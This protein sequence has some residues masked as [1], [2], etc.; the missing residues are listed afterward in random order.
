MLEENESLYLESEDLQSAFNLFSVPD[1]WL[2]F[3]SYSKKVDSSAF[4]LPAGK[5][6]RPAL[7]VVRMGWHSAVAL[8][9]EAVRDL[10]FNRAGVPKAISV[11]KGRPLPAGKNLAVVYLDNFDEIRVIQSLDVDLADEGKEMSDHHRRFNQA[12]DEA[13]LPRNLGKQ[14]IHAYGGGMQGGHF[15][16]VEGVLKVVPDKLRNYIQLSLALLGK[17]Q[18]SEYHLRHWAGKTAFLATFKRSLL[19]TIFPTIEDSRKGP[20]PPRST[21]LDEIFV[22]MIQS[23]LSQANLRAH[24]SLEISCTDASPTGGGSGTATKLKTHEPL[25]PPAV[26]FEGVCGECGE[27]IDHEDLHQKY[28]CEDQWDLFTSGGKS[29]LDEYC[30]E[31]CLAIEH[32][33]PECK[34]F[35]AARGKP[36]RT[37]SGRWI[38]GPPALRSRSKPWG[39][40]GLK[41]GDQIKLRQGNSMAK[42]SLQGVEEGDERG[43]MESIEHPWGS[44]LWYTEEAEALFNAPGMFA[45][46]FSHCCFGGRRTKWTCILHNI[47]RVHEVMHLDSCPGHDGLLP[48]EVHL[49]D[50]G[51][52]SFDTAKEA[53]YPWRLCQVFARAV[54]EQLM[55]QFPSPRGDMPFGSV[56]AIMSTLRTATKGFQCENH[57]LGAAR[58]I[59]DLM[60]TMCPGRERDHLKEMLRQ[61]CLRGTDIKLMSEAEDGSQSVMAPYPAF[62]W[63]WKVKLAWKWKQSQHINELEVAAF[64]VEFRR[65]TRSPNSLGSRFFNVTDSRV[66]FHVLSNG[67]IK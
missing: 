63:D 4:G 18:W 17:K 32:W 30:D 50:D 35:S 12:C 11:E 41:Q 8:V 36:V 55:R 9:Q 57:A 51:S 49:E 59:A 66:M 16:G 2:G 43:K 39:L 31:G 47:P 67:K 24:L 15:D 54:K 7:S 13:G 26:K 14:L 45:T 6:L 10:V 44:H 42:R 60:Q 25:S 53:T 20:V 5:L 27:A 37:T 23:P 58:R 1:E 28:R 56:T 65:R 29:R 21:V 62:L 38:Q 40:A 22:L 46:A 34:S 64:L 52:L 33:A 48:Y 19:A 3:F 61:V